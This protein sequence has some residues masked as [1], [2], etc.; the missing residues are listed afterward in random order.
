M[1][2]KHYI[3]LKKTRE[4]K[5]FTQADVAAYLG[6]SRQAISQWE[7]GVA[8]PD[9]DNLMLLCKLYQVS[10]NVLIL[11][12]EES[13]IEEK[14]IKIENYTPNEKESKEVAN[15]D[16]HSAME[17]LSI[18]IILALSSQIPF[19]GMLI[20]IVVVW[21]TVKNRKN[22][23]VV[24]FVSIIAFII[25]SYNTLNTLSYYVFTNYGTS[26]IEKY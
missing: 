15:I 12:N 10:I 25:G 18:L 11:T 21:R 22:V 8:Y 17:F 7:R 16:L 13:N 19:L 20:P 14:N 23:K 3:K 5:G 6:V 4:E 26:T 9:I 24:L 2:E 1:N